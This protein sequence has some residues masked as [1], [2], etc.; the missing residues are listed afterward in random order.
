MY[1]DSKH[2]ALSGNEKI[3]NILKTLV[4]SEIKQSR[5]TTI[6]QYLP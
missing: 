6:L 1:F 2:R 3:L 5:P 4:D